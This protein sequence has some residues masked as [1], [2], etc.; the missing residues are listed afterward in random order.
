MYT[1]MNVSVCVSTCLVSRCWGEGADADVDISRTLLLF[2]HCLCGRKRYFMVLV[3]EQFFNV[4]VT[5][6]LYT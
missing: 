6:C 4:F 3:L 5:S 1:C 2:K